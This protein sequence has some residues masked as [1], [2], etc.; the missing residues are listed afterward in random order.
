MQYGSTAQTLV[1][2]D[3]VISLQILVF[4]PHVKLLSRLADDLADSLQYCAE[5]SG[6]SRPDNKKIRS[7]FR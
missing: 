2:V 1:G 5:G 7:A 6:F 3:H 4:E